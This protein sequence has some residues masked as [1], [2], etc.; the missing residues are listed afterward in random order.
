LGER[1]IP[2]VLEKRVAQRRLRIIK[3]AAPA[4]DQV[5]VHPAVI[6]VVEKCEAR[7]VSFRKVVRIRSHVYVYPGNSALR[8][9][10]LLEE[11][12]LCLLG[13]GQPTGCGASKKW[14]PAGHRETARES[15]LCAYNAQ[16]LAPSEAGLDCRT[17]REGRQVGRMAHW[18]GFSLP[19]VRTW[20]P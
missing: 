8:S 12:R 7:S 19:R 11:S 15:C 10:N 3:I 20:T 1:S 5:D 18:L 2:V 4:V 6:V 9:C 16:E 13:V 17:L 14:N